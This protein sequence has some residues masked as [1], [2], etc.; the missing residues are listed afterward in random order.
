MPFESLAFNASKYRVM[1][2]LA[3]STELFCSVEYCCSGTLLG[4]RREKTSATLCP[5][6][7]LV[8]RLMGV[9][10]IQTIGHSFLFFISFLRRVH[11]F[12]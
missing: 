3:S 12:G 8:F 9:S 4:P 7:L 11:P 1:T 6:G 5:A 10:I 2:R